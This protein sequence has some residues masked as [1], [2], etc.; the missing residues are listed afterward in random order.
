MTLNLIVVDSE[1]ETVP[2][3]IANHPVIKEFARR[4]KK[5]PTDLILDSNYHHGAMK[6]L[7]DQER[8]GRPDIPHYILLTALD[9]ALNKAGLLRI[10]IHTRNNK[11]ISINPTTQLPQSY[12][13]FIGLMEDLFKNKTAGKEPLMQLEK[14]TVNDILNFLGAEPFLLDPEGEKKTPREVGQLMAKSKNP[15]IIVG[16]FSHGTFRSRLDGKGFCIDPALLKAWT[17]STRLIYSYE[18]VICLPEKRLQ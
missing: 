9:S 17:A 13:R 16:G 4:K 7:R 11:I 18:D 8:R 1:L 15:A 3:R 6:N 2:K 5:K 14:G 12:N 10:F